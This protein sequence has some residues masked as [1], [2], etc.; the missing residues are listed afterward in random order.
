MSRFD[1]TGKVVLIAGASR[2]IG[3]ACAHGF[4]QHGATVICSSRSK[5]ADCEKVAEA[6][7][8]KGGKAVSAELH[9]GN[10]NITTKSSP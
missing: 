10:L 9:L 2:G 7:R 4:A 3:E 6:I 5:Q 8:A 1:F